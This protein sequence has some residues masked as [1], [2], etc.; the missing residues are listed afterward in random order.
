MSSVGFVPSSLSPFLAT[1]N[2]GI[3]VPSFEAYHTCLT[4][5]ASAAIGTSGF[6]QVFRSPLA[7]A[8]RTIIVGTTNDE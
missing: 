8:R 6:H 5:I 3:F 7:T 1:T 4:S 2:I